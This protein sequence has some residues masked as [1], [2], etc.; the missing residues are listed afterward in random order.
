MSV[1]ERPSSRPAADLVA[2]AE[3]AHSLV[4]RSPRAAAGRARTILEQAER[5]GSA[6]ARVAAL[7]ALGYAQ[8]QLADPNAASTM[9]RAVRLADRSSLPARAAFA[10][11]L[12]AGI[13][14]DRGNVRASLRE[15]D[16]ARDG[17]H[18]ADLA[19]A[20]TVRLAILANLGQD[21]V[22]DT[23][24]ARALAVLRR[25]GDVIWQ[26]RLLQNRGLLFWS[27]GDP[28]AEADLLEAR[29]LW[30]QLG[31]GVAVAVADVNLM[32]ASLSQG[33]VITALERLDGIDTTDLPER[34][35]A[36]VKRHGARVLL[37]ARLV[38]EAVEAVR[39]AQ[40]ILE[41]SH[42]EGLVLETRLELARLMEIAGRGDEAG[43]IATVV[44]RSAAARGK[45]LLAAQAR[46]LALGAPR[47]GDSPSALRSARRAVATFESLG[48]TGEAQRARVLAA[49]IAIAQGRVALGER[50]LAQARRA[51][52][53]RPVADR[54][55]TW[56]VE[57]Q[58]RRARGDAAGAERALRAGLGLLEDYRGALGALE[59][60][61]A[62]STLGSDLS[63]VGLELAVESGDPAR[64]LEW[65]ERLRGNALR[66]P[67]VRP[68]ADPQ[69]RRR[70]AELR[71][72]ADRIRERE[73][74]GKPL[75][76]LAAR[77]A[78]LEAAIRARSRHMRGEGGRRHRPSRPAHGGAG[79][80]RARARRVRGA[81]RRAARGHPRPWAVGAP[82]ARRGRRGGRAGV[83][84]LRARTP[85]RARDEL[86][87]ASGRARQ[88][89]GG[90]GGARTDARPPASARA[91]RRAARDRPDRGSPRAPLGRAPLAA[92]PR[93]RRRA[94]ALDLAR[95]PRPAAPARDAAGSDR[96]PAPAPHR[97]R[98]SRPRRRAAAR[99]RPHRRGRN[100]GGDPARDRRRRAR[101]PRLPRAL[102]VRQPAL[103]LPRACGR[104]ADHARAATPP[105]PTRPARPLR[106]RP[107]ALRPP[108]GRRA[109]R[110]LPQRSWRW[111][112][113]RS[114]RASSRSPTR[115]RG[116]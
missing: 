93:G 67:P 89:G 23:F 45:K 53:R 87:S 72:V 107:R 110:P 2:A 46:M 29:R 41:R 55:E 91:R 39:R 43:R 27:R 56:G 32:R 84:P 78:E 10:R 38:D 8:Y 31:A 30:V 57:A 111:A 12:L 75:G 47:D 115:P 24:S 109:A 106:L 3:A 90:R 58:L 92:R 85:G 69:L 62:A 20:D 60:R 5:A 26:A 25:E 22:H 50:L 17:L 105:P 68:P 81:G 108:P 114:S 11:R 74:S 116:A 99:D 6:E 49:R 59:L 7:H 51:G 101:A 19:R 76:G 44:A 73:E 80:R 35:T 13:Y 16:R 28:R 97:P 4:E 86:S 61:T 104:A 34:L 94:L 48:S 37:A 103:L 1:R 98:G 42:T 71:H 88:R 33:D 113:E 36:V 18:G 96:R 66:L 77:Q 40:G 15:I 65:A 95:R 21:A 79:A 54:I 63:R 102:P 14:A 9:Q 64:V 83:A 112:R 100:G 70:Q 82:Q 52:V